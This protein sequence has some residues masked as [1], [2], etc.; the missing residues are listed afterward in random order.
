[1]ECLGAW[2][3]TRHAVVKNED[4][5]V[6]SF[7]YKPP[8]CEV[9]KTEFPVMVALGAGPGVKPVPLI[10]DLPLLAPPF[11]V[12]G[13]PSSTGE[14]TR[15]AYSPSP[16]DPVLRIGRSRECVLRAQDVSVSRVHAL[17]SFD[18]NAFGVKDNE[19]K[20]QTLIRPKEKQVLD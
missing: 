3:V 19:S 12:L 16:H 20:F 10:P 4:S 1:M 11:I 15:V 9:C 5:R 14:R 6:K 13:A 7:S 8:S 17:I 2:F 18:G